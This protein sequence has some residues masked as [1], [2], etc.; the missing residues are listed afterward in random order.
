MP[1]AHADPLFASPGLLDAH[2]DAAHKLAFVVDMMR[3]LSRQTDPQEMV[4]NYGRRMRQVIPADGHMSLSR[5]DLPRPQ[6]R[7]TRSSQW[8]AG[9]NPWK[10][11]DRL[12]VFNGGLLARLIWGD[13]PVLID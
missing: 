3:D 7:I 13:E 12:P 9:V 5:R 6:V 4:A 10:Q 8:E 1:P 11:K 2:G